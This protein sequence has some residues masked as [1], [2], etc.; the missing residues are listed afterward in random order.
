MDVTAIVPAA[1]GGTRFGGDLP[2][3]FLPLKGIPI[4]VR[5]LLALVRSELIQHLIVVVPPGEEARGCELVRRFEIPREV[6]V[7][8]GGEERQESVYRGLQRARATTDLVVIHDGVRPFLSQGLLEACIQEAAVWGAAVA[9]VPAKETIKEVREGVV[10]ETPQ[11]GRLWIAQT[12]Q[13]FRYPL[14]LEAHRRAQTEG[15]LGTDDAS[16]AERIGVKVRI[17][18]GSYENIKITTPGDL[19]FAEQLLDREALTR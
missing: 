8:E 1:G 3:Q 14:L 11:R 6:E 16:L 17:V 4:V 7:V 10:F 9:A 18:Q 15:F 12:P 19:L 13:T 2:K 5:T